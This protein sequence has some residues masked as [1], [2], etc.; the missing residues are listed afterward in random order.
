MLFRS[1][2]GLEVGEGAKAKAE[3]GFGVRAGARARAGATNGSIHGGRE[4]E[5]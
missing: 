5:S 4:A 2:Q 3:T 1:G